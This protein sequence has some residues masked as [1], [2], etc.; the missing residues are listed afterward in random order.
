MYSNR[1]R[2]EIL[3]MCVFRGHKYAEAYYDAPAM[4]VNIKRWFG[5]SLK[6]IKSSLTRSEL[7]D[8]LQL[9]PDDKHA[10]QLVH[11]SRSKLF[12]EDHYQDLAR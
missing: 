6:G 11:H 3:A 12:S 9:L 7:M 10:E 8:L 4:R 5:S 1:E 2:M